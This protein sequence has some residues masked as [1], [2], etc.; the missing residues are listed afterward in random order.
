[1]SRYVGKT[2]DLKNVP[3]VDALIPSGAAW[4]H[5]WLWSEALPKLL[6]VESL[7]KTAIVTTDQ[8]EICISAIEKAIS[9]SILPVANIRLC[10]WHKVR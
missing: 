3:L 5:N 8:D 6:P 2:G 4:V 9:K 1:M 10:A 7:R